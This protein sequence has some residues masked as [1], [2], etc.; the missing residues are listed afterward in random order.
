MKKKSFYEII[1]KLKEFWLK[2]QCVIYKPLDL[3]IG[4]GTF[5]NQT[6]FKAIDNKPASAAY[7]QGSRRPCDGRFGNNTNRLQHYYQFQV[8]LK[9]SP[10]NIQNTYINSLKNLGIDTNINDIRF[11]EDNWSNPT[12]GAWGVGWEV[13]LNGMEITQFTYFQQ[14]GGINCDPIMIEITYG[15][16]RLAMFIQNIN[17]VYDIIWQKK[18]KITYKDIFLKNEIEQSYYNFLNSNEKFL[19]NCFELFLTESIRLI[20][21]EPALI[22]PAY[23]QILQAIHQFNLLD[24]T[25]L[26]SNTERNRYILKIRNV[27]ILIAKK[28][29]QKYGKL[30]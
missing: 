22:F 28:Y 12:L 16:E 17:S 29:I 8:I 5:H 13:W 26:L 18:N 21:I 23:E 3:P 10:K 14:V 9:P 7:I 4:A 19:F 11:V 2:Q 15:L 30:K 20:N 6:F 27:T 1:Q 24:A 25:N